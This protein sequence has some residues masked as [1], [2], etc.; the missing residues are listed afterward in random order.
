MHISKFSSRADQRLAGAMAASLTG[1]LP[2]RPAVAWRAAPP[3]WTSFAAPTSS[4]CRVRSS[5][6]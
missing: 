3:A 5:E 1:A 2:A 4:R 6:L